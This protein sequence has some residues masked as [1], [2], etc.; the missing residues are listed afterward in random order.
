MA[1]IKE[2]AVLAKVSQATASFVL[3]GRGDQYRISSETQQ[4][5]M[6]AARA[7]DYRPNISAR[8]LRSN[9]ETVVP[10]IALFWTT[11]P[12]SQLIARYMRGIQSALGRMDA[13]YELLI[14]PYHGSRLHEIKSL[15]TATRFNG[16]IIALPTEEDER[17]LEEADLKV[18]IV[19]H[20]RDSSRYCTVNVDSYKSGR[21]VA[22]LFAA[23]GHT[24]IGLIVPTISSSAIRLRMQGFLDRCSES[25]VSVSESFIRYGDFTEE[26]GYRLAKSLFARQERPSALFC[27]SD[28]MAVGALY[29]LHELNIRVPEQVEV[30]GYDDDAASSFSI[31]SLTTIH[32]PVEEMAAACVQLLTDLM[33]HKISPPYSRRFETSL[34]IRE[35]CGGLPSAE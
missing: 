12:R 13:E 10:I 20:Q 6:E 31:P 25:G 1:N 22:D 16:A 15:T 33:S 35:S 30:V 27:I 11:D 24:R 19:L 9:G 23:R 34:V 32:L 4:R 28:Q 7:L 14:H 17:F 18:P 26:G 29:A 8:R 5:V 21:T 2:I 3:S